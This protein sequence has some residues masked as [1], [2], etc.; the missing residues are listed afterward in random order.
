MARRSPA[1][2]L[3]IHRVRYR[4]SGPHRDL[5][6][7]NEWERTFRSCLAPRLSRAGLKVEVF[8]WNDFH[9]RYVLSNLLGISVPNGFDTTSTK[10]T[11]TWTRLGRKDLEDIQREFDPAANRHDL[12]HRF[13]I[14]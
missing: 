13:T 10:D 2:K 7:V 9:D 4:G 3:E 6:E 5:V 12:K 1:P 8:L 11:T 14:P